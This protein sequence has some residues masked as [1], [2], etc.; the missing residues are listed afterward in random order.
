MLIEDLFFFCQRSFLLGSL[1]QTR[2]YY[3]L[4]KEEIKTKKILPQHEYLVELKK[5]KTAIDSGQIAQKTWLD[6]PIGN[7]PNTETASIKQ[8]ELVKK[9]H[10]QGLS[11]LCNI[12]DDRLELDNI[13]QPCGVYGAVDM[14][15]RGLHTVYPLEVKKDQGRHDLIGQIYKY[16]LFHKLRLHYRIYDKVQ[17]VTVCQSYEP[18]VL[19]ELKQM[20]IMTLI[21]RI[22][23]EKLD[24]TRV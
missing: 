13:E 14:V 21:Y 19:Q 8:K 16:D 2:T 9:I 17:S 12:L 23:S 10:V 1:E 3:T 24:I 15:Y 18:H 7:L 11:Q 22:G 6:E 5:I 4:L 20:G